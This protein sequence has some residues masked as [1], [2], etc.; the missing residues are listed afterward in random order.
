[1]LLEQKKSKTVL[2]TFRNLW[3]SLEKASY[4]IFYKL[5][6]QKTLTTNLI[7]DFNYIT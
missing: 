4:Y 6:M 3:I 7:L 2:Q 5:R 1:M